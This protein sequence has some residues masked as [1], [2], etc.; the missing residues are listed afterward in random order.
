[1]SLK[2]KKS[3]GFTLLEMIMALII[4]VLALMGATIMAQ[5]GIKYSNFIFNQAEI[6]NEIQKSITL[7]VKQIRETRQADSGSFAMEKAESNQFI[8]YSNIDKTPDVERVRYLR[9]NNCLKEGI[10][11]PTGTPPRYL[12]A[13]EQINDLTCNVANSESEPIF[14]YYKDYPSPSTLLTVPANLSQIKVIK[15]YLRITSTGKTP[16]PNSKIISEYVSPRNINQ[17]E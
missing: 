10:I 2:Y 8:F 6:T 4:F 15:I 13:N 12:D 17:E 7:M 1:M 16:L 5:S 9:L 11:K 14:S 3:R